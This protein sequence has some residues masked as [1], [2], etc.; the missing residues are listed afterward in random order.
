MDFLAGGMFDIF[1][2]MMPFYRDIFRIAGK[3]NFIIEYVSKAIEAGKHSFLRKIHWDCVFQNSQFFRR[4]IVNA[5]VPLGSK[6][7]SKALE[8]N[9]PIAHDIHLAD[10]APIAPAFGRN[11]GLKE[12][13]PGV[14]GI[15]CIYFVQFFIFF[16]M[17]FP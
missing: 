3:F 4:E 5:F 8:L 15:C 16:R 9:Q 13:M 17:F 1:F 7:V 10:T 14:V 12:E 2:H 6:G 11:S